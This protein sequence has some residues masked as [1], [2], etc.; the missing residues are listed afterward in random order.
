MLHNLYQQ[1]EKQRFKGCKSSKAGFQAQNAVLLSPQHRTC[2]TGGTHQ[3][4]SH[5]QDK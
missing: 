3:N 2:D 5:L 1:V 4:N